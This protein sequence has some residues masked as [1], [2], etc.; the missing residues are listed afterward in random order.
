MKRINSKHLNIFDSIFNWSL[1]TYSDSTLIEPF[2]NNFILKKFDAK[3]FISEIAIEHLKLVTDFVVSHF[4]QWACMLQT[5][6][7]RAG[8]ERKYQH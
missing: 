4:H 2:I 7:Y 8:G 3:T 5:Y 6:I 1:V